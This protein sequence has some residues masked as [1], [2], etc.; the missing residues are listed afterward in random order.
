MQKI[1]YKMHTDKVSCDYIRR[2][3]LGKFLQYV[4][5]NTELFNKYIKYYYNTTDNPYDTNGSLT[6]QCWQT[7]RTMKYLLSNT[8]LDMLDIEL[9]PLLKCK[10]IDNKLVVNNNNV[11]YKYIY[12]SI[13][14]IFNN[15]DTINVCIYV[16]GNSDDD[17]NTI[18]PGHV[19]NIILD[20]APN[21]KNINVRP[22]FIV[23]SFIYKYTM[24]IWTTND[25]NDVK[26]LLSKYINI[27]LSTTDKF[28]LQDEVLA[29][30]LFGIPDITDYNNVRLVNR[31]KLQ[32]LIIEKPTYFDYNSIKS[33]IL[34]L[35]RLCNNNIGYYEDYINSFKLLIKQKG[36]KYNFYNEKDKNLIYKIISIIHNDSKYFFIQECKYDCKIL[37]IY[38]QKFNQI[39]TMNKDNKIESIKNINS[40]YNITIPLFIQIIEDINKF[41]KILENYEN[42]NKKLDEYIYF[43]STKKGE[44]LYNNTPVNKSQCYI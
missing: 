26:S 2:S 13:D 18:F 5:D 15:P 39:I 12:N 27:F 28:T 19:F 24:K 8:E 21:P 16:S 23:Q 33:R 7:T 17:E 43:D 29:R 9:E 37:N 1:K 42:F 41:K 35:V 31:P 20:K 38:N 30:Q 34:N 22:I 40:L 4:K 14:N 25:L 11:D 6:S 3:L 44:L 36:Y 10:I 32:N